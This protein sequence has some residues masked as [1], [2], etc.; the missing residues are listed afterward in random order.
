[1]SLS[2]FISSRMCLLVYGSC[3]AV[4]LATRLEFAKPGAS[5]K[6]CWWS[7][8]SLAG[9]TADWRTRTRPPLVALDDLF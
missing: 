8:Q 5:R 3:V 9:F 6:P 7:V 1:M 4:R 2:D